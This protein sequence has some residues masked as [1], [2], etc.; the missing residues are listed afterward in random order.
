SPSARGTGQ[1]GL[2]LSLRLLATPP[3]RLSRV[4]R[5]RRPALALYTSPPLWL[6]PSVAAGAPKL[7]FDAPPRSASLRDLIIEPALLS[8][9]S[10]T[11]SL[12]TIATRLITDNRNSSMHNFINKIS[13]DGVT[14]EHLSYIELR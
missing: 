1:A 10:A 9:N 12:V 13:G 8:N 4:H 3:H 5:P 14:W 7:V 11:A 2:H 6:A